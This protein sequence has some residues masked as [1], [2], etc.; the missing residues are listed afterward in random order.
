MTDLKLAPPTA[1]EL[2]R[3][4]EEFAIDYLVKNKYEIVTR[5]FRLYRGE[6]DVIAYDGRALVFVEVKTRMNA[7]FG[8]PEEYVTSAKQR[9]I[10]KIA[11]GYLVQNN[12]TEVECR[13]DVL[14]LLYD[15]REGFKIEHFRDAF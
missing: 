11:G 6:I 8:R 9:Q 2:G 5:S 10:R 12:L 4:G 13:F 7:D 1:Q 14:S 3:M 15:E